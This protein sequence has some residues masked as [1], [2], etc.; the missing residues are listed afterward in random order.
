MIL[1]TKT[2]VLRH[3]Q[4][5]AERWPYWLENNDGEGMSLSAHDADEMIDM[6]FRQYF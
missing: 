6:Y 4:Q 3:N 5:D 1:E 2:Y